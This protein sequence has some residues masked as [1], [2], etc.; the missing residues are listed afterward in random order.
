MFC[1]SRADCL[2]TGIAQ[3]PSA[4]AQDDCS[5]TT[6]TPHANHLQ[7]D[8]SG[9]IHLPHASHV[10]CSCR[11]LGSESA[12]VQG[13]AQPCDA[14]QQGCLLC[15]AQHAQH[16]QQ[17]PDARQFEHSSG[18]QPHDEGIYSAGAQQQQ[19]WCACVTAQHA[20][21]EPNAVL[22]KHSSGQHASAGCSYSPEAH[23]AQQQQQQQQCEEGKVQPH[24][25]A[26]HQP[27]AQSHRQA[28][29]R[30]EQDQAVLEGPALTLS[31]GRQTSQGSLLAVLLGVPQGGSSWAGQ[32][33]GDSEQHG[34][35]G[36]CRQALL[37]AL[38]KQQ[39]SDM[40]HAEPL[41]ASAASSGAYH[42]SANTSAAQHRLQSVTRQP[43]T[44][45]CAAVSWP[46]DFRLE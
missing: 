15:P 39:P 22:F 17:E 3:T 46:I 5:D 6:C 41:P 38:P 32:T 4:P 36:P 45:A 8:C 2:V 18:Q 13:G 42:H 23:H 24:G 37:A 16:A 29:G 43:G 1:C 7:Y 26:E 25:L 12:A 33:Q 28:L 10:W 30:S 35:T 44:V 21:H 14:V 11:L 20:Q 27:H 34:N 40:Y 9:S 19:R 31:D